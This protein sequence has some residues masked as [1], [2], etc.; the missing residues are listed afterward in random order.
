MIANR[1]L[2]TAL[3]VSCLVT[4]LGVSQGCSKAEDPQQATAGQH[5]PSKLGDL[6]AFRGIAEDVAAK[7]DASDLPGA[8]ARIKDLEKTWDDAEAGIKPRAASDWHVLDKAIDR[9]LDAL[10]ASPPQQAD[11]KAAMVDLLKAFDGLQ[12]S[13]QG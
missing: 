4:A 6:S 2:L 9:A 11:C 13:R 10:R 1:M 7:V 8:K 12:G 3:A 5:A